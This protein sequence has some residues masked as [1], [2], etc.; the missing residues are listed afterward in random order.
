MFFF[1]FVFDFLTG[2]FRNQNVFQYLG[3]GIGGTSSGRRAVSQADQAHQTAVTD[4]EEDIQEKDALLA[5]VEARD[6]IEFGMIP[7]GFYTDFIHDI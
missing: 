7:V 5:K 6:M 4:V 3:F 2:D 1:I